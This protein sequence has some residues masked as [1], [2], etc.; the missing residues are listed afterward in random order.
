MRSQAFLLGS[1][2]LAL[3]LSRGP[4]RPR[5]GRL[6]TGAGSVRP[7]AAG[8]PGRRTRHGPPRLISRLAALAFGV[9]VALVVGGVAG[10]PA[11]LAA[12]AGAERGLRKLEPAAE[13]TARQRRSEELPLVLDLLGICLQAG[14]PLVA[15]LE[16]VAEARPGPF[17][18]DLAVVAGLQRLGST[19]AEAWAELA[20]DPELSP[21]ARAVG[22]SAES[23]SRLAAAFE[24]MAAE[25]RSSLAARGGLPCP[26]GRRDSDGP[27]G[28]VLP[29]RLRQPRCRPDRAR[30]G[31]GGTA[32]R[33]E[34]ARSGRD[35]TARASLDRGRPPLGGIAGAVE[36]RLR[37]VEPDV[38]CGNAHPRPRLGWSTRSAPT[39]TGPSA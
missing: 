26:A 32:V 21:V 2:G 23:G 20:V 25:K 13:R 9:A 7:P 28:S 6:G 38:L 35:P 36:A 11:G 5:A 37:G 17:S 33:P 19:P 39:H 4:S 27:A 30:P 12:A 18:R 15:A 34:R 3:A 31:Q 1:L 8:S 29:A 10:I 14:M 24:R 22:R 16:T